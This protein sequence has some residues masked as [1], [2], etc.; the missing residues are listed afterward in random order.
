MCSATAAQGLKNS[1]PAWAMPNGL[2]LRAMNESRHNSVMCGAVGL[3]V[4]LL[5]AVEAQSAL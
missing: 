5:H 2:N 4:Q 3:C 1:T